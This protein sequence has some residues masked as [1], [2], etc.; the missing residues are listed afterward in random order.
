M[1]PL[2][3]PPRLRPGATIG[4]AAISGPVDGERLDAGVAA[5]ER[6][7]YRILPASN[8]RERRGFLAGSDRRRVDGYRELLRNPAVDAILFARGGYGASRILQHL[9]PAEIG[10]R[11]IIHLGGSDLTALFAF[12]LAHVGLVSMFGPMVAVSMPDDENLDWEA[13]LGGQVP[14]PHRFEERDILATGSAR[15]PLVGGCLSLLAS[16]AGTPEAV[17]A[18]GAVLFWED[19]AEPTYRLDRM[20]TQLERAGTLHGLLGMVIGSVVPRRDGIMSPRCLGNRPWH[21]TKRA[22]ATGS[23]RSPLCTNRTSA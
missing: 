18:D 7:G 14:A 22:C 9:D 1:K 15:G 19:V 11:P 6:K 4:V 20:L 12:L 10:A 2:I 21:T 5:L 8:I 3:R 13:V 23:R 16:L 17:D